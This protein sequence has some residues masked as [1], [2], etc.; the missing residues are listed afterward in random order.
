MIQNERTN[1]RTNEQLRRRF[2]KAR[3]QAHLEAHQGSSSGHL[4]M[5]LCSLRRARSRVRSNVCVY[6]CLSS[7]VRVRTDYTLRAP[8]NA[9]TFV[10]SAP[11]VCHLGGELPALT[12]TYSD[13]GPKSAPVVYIMPSAS[14]SCHVSG[15]GG[16]WRDVVGCGEH[17][18]VDCNMFRVVSA[19]P[20]GSPFGSSSPLTADHAGTQWRA[21]FPVISPFDQANAHARLIDALHIERVHAVV[22]ASMGGMAALQFA[23]HFPERYSRIVAI[24]TTPLTSAST[25]ALRSV[26]RAAV[27]IDPAFRDG[28]YTADDGPVHGMAVARQMGTIC[29]RSRREFDERFSPLRDEEARLFPVER[30]L[31]HV[32]NS[33]G[34]RFDPNC[35]LTLS[36]AM[37]LQNIAWK[38]NGDVS[39]AVEQIPRDKEFLL[40]PVTQD[41]LIPPDELDRLAALLG[42]RGIRTAHERLES[43]YGHD[44]FLKSPDMMN[45]RLRAFLSPSDSGVTT[46][47]QYLAGLAE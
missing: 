24:A 38:H 22:G 16:W 36:L 18:G 9:Q 26:Q 21:R 31:R 23:L 30:Y 45:A 2:K 8:P 20:L 41:A 27:R 6:R 14:H 15:D 43:V 39:S 7:S 1:E 32:A 47:R 5:R 10:S 3:Y 11:F 29:Y 40:L 12:L 35:W 33:F 19:S 42:Q 25:Q 28:D 4:I 44:A 17:F 13:I 46:Y 37:D 34:V